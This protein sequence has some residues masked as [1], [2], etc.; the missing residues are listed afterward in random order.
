MFAICSCH[1]VRSSLLL[2]LRRVNI[3]CRQRPSFIK[4]D[5]GLTTCVMVWLLLSV[6]CDIAP[7]LR[8]VCLG[9]EAFGLEEPAVDIRGEA[10]RAMAEKIGMTCWPDDPTERKAALDAL[11]NPLVERAVAACR[12]A[13]KAALRSDD[14]AEAFVRRADAGRLLAAA[15][16]GRLDDAGDGGRNAADRGSCR[17]GRGR[18]RGARHGFR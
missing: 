4:S 17:Q 10:D 15:A 2:P 3:A 8:E 1:G 5:Q 13:H 9:A 12:A 7:D 18:R 6:P 16:R 14:A 11:L